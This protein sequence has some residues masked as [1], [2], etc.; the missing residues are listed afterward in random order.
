MPKRPLLVFYLLAGY[1]L[2]FMIW[3]M[4]HLVDLHQELAELQAA[5]SQKPLYLSDYNRKL[6]MVYGEGAAVLIVLLLGIWQVRNSF[7]REFRLTQQ[8]KNFMLSITHELRSPL[9]SIKLILQTLHKRNM[10]RSKVEELSKAA[11]GDVERLQSLVDNI[12][13]AA[14]LEDHNY[15]YDKEVLNL[16]EFVREIAENSLLPY[17]DRWNL[18]MQIDP[19]ITIQADVLSLSSLILNLI[20]NALKYSDPGS[21]IIIRLKQSE[22]NPQLEIA[23]E[24]IGVPEKERENIFKRFYR[25]GNEDTRNTHGTGIGLFIVQGVAEAHNAKVECLPNTP[26]GT[27]FRV[28]FEAFDPTAV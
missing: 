9:A 26:K 24:G 27:I 15:V 12:L 5:Q 25:V 20:S 14:R 17:Q 28:I 7:Q 19:D 16:S 11:T 13:F 2:I 10:E 23:D 1:I 6:I 8:Q 4:Y 18:K 3:W 21:N 22:G